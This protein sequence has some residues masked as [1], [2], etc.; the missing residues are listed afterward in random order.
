MSDFPMIRQV[1]SKPIPA[2][3]HWKEICARLRLKYNQNLIPIE[4]LSYI[5]GVVA[6]RFP[7]EEN[8][9]CPDLR[10]LQ[11]PVETRR[12]DVQEQ[13][14]IPTQDVQLSLLDDPV[15]VNGF[16]VP[17]RQPLPS[18]DL[19]VFLE[20]GQPW[21]STWTRDGIRPMNV[22]EWFAVLYSG[23]KNLPSRED[24]R[25]DFH[26]WGLEGLY[27]GGVRLLADNGLVG[28]EAISRLDSFEYQAQLDYIAQHG[29]HP[30]SLQLTEKDYIHKVLTPMDLPT[31][32]RGRHSRRGESLEHL[33]EYENVVSRYLVVSTK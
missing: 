10:S 3:N 32:V 30:N 7:L 33:P 24:M 11:Q 9:Y 13:I 1:L 12:V 18:F 16:F 26:R 25:H 4:T 28:L 22:E 17:K 27:G 23:S 20:G 15:R 5:E 14:Y 29:Y 31:L 8:Y 19:R 6:D 2:F 21:R